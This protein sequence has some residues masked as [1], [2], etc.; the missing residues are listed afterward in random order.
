MAAS[1]SRR[2]SGTAS[3]PLA[4]PPRRE[5]AWAVPAESWRRPRTAARVFWTV[6]NIVSAPSGTFTCFSAS[7]VCIPLPYQPMALGPFT[8]NIAARST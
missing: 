2:I 4:L 8:M 6:R 5:S 3:T 1:L 7:G